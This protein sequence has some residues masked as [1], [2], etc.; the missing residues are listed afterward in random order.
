[1]IVTVPL[2]VLKHGGVSFDPR[3]PAGKRAA[4]RRL[5]FGY[6]EK[7]AMLFDE[8]FWKA[9]GKTHIVRLTD[10][11]ALPADPGHAAAQR[12][13]GPDRALRRA[14]RRSA[15]RTRAPPRRSRLAH[16]A[17]REALGGGPIPEPV[18]AH[19]TAWRRDPFARGSY[20]TVIAGRPRTDF[21]ALAAPVGPILF[22]GEATNG[23]RNGYSDGAMSSG[24]REAKRLLQAPSVS[25][26][27]G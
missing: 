24:I 1:M 16:D 22:A 14:D 26:S 6:F 15:S 27:A 12:L 5:G 9:G 20:S 18:A 8:P 11:F 21:D 7:V 2:G 19:A 23:I 3:L 4:I 13:P 25:L 17:I 10:P